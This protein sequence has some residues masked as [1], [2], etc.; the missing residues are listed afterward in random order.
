VTNGTANGVASGSF[1]AGT[2][3]TLVAAPAPS[4]QYFQQWTGN[5]PVAN[6]FAST[7]TFTMPSSTVTVSA[8]YYT[9]APIPQPVATH[10]RL[11]I[12]QSDL[13]KFQ[14][15]A[16]AS[17]PIYQQGLVPLLNQAIADY[18]TKFFPGGVPNPTYPDL[19]DTQGYQGLI[20]EQYALIFALHSLIDP[21]PANRILHAQRAR[22]LIM[23]ALNEAAKG[24]LAGAP[25]RDPLF[26][27]YNRGNETS[28]AW[29]LVVDWIYNA[30]D[31][32]G[33]PILTAADKLTIRNVF[34][35][36][37]NAC[38][39]ASTTGGDHPSPVGIVNNPAL[40]P[41]G[42]AY[43]MAS[44]NYYLG[45]A[46]L[47]TLMSLAIDPV[48]DPAINLSAPAAVLGNSLRSYIAD[49][50]GAWL[51][52]EYAM[53]GDPNSV[54]SGYN[55]S[56]TAK[57]GLAS[58]GLP[59][60]GMLYG[61][62]Y[63]FVLGQLLALKTAGFADPTLIG[64][65]AALANNAPVWDRFM[66]GMTTSLVPSAQVYPGYGYMGPVYQMASYGDIL[67]LWMTPDF[68]QPFALLGL[69]DQKN[70]DTSRLNA[71]RWFVTNVLEGGSASLLNRV[72]S[73]WSYG[74]Q[75][76][77]LTFLILDPTAPA[78]TDPR[79][80]YPT[81]FYDAPQGRLVEH[82]DWTANATMFDFRCSWISI[83]HQQADANQ[84]EFYR[85]GEWLTK[86][87]ANYDNNIV[88]LTTDYHNTLS[89]KN[90]C[91]NGVPTSLGWWEGPFWAN[92]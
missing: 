34:V 79:P 60:E 83:N 85:K 53:L 3:V 41:G 44:N 92:G 37:A 18:N 2:V 56:A 10:P 72:A 13:P 9:P 38:L 84:F 49:A 20:T 61:H 29:P 28:E 57:V 82:T 12:T 52:Q 81:A 86:G 4:G 36:W 54:R 64:P 42:D 62:S 51:Y 7:T 75:D 16:T 39:S 14:S 43:R 50:T 1:A 23:Y 35:Q 66:K 21:N 88:G 67:R 68:A 40:L 69:L 58:G 76:A 31:A 91:Q 59:P 15:W 78:A 87:V 25:F 47:V 5:A 65:Q 90:W 45:H 27:T 55:L 32:Q 22:N 48:D 63:S 17:N 89:L 6:S 73:P 77:L 8:G 46:R 80:N 30:T 11:W 74:V 33:N 71:E 19:G 70:G 26:V 24:P